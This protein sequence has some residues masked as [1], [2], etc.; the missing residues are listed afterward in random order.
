MSIFR[1]ASALYPFVNLDAESADFSIDAIYKKQYMPT[2]ITETDT[3][4]NIKVHVP[5]LTKSQIKLNVVKDVLTVIAEY[6]ERRDEIENK[7]HHYESSPG[8]CSRSFTLSN[9]IDFSVPIVANLADGI[10][11]VEFKKR[12]DSLLKEIT[13]N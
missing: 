12:V 13:I 4:V 9:Q 10:L 6:P 3:T 8:K 1:L 7:T 11:N 2:D 5:G